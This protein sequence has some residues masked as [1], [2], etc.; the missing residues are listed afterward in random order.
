MKNI[1]SNIFNSNYFFVIIKKIL[2]RFEKN[3]SVD[4]KKWVRFN[5][6]YTTK[7]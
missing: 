7:E 1:F 4:A 6:K 5:T 3:T 2:K